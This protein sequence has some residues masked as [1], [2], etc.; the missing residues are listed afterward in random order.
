MFRAFLLL[1]MLI[2]HANQPA[3]ALERSTPEA[4]GISS[5]AILGFVDAAEDSIDALHSFMLLRMNTGHLKEQADAFWST[6]RDTW[7]ESFLAV[8]VGL[9]PGTHF[10]YNTGATYMAGLMVQRLTGGRP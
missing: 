10:V 1:F 2:L 8:P 3:A 7:A 6:E 9:K 4:Q 5:R